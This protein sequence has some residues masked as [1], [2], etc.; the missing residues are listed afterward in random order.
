MADQLP[1]PFGWEMKFTEQNVRYFI[2]H[3]SRTTTFQDP[4]KKYLNVCVQFVSYSGTH[5]SSKYH[6]LYFIHNIKRY[7]SNQNT[8]CL[9]QRCLE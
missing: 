3:N 8:L 1:L 9:S 4:G 5:L 6:K 7:S 2:D